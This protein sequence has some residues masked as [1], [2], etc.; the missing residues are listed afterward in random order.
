MT[1]SKRKKGKD[2]P[3]PK[4][5]G[6]PW[7]V[8]DMWDLA[9]LW[10]KPRTVES[11]ARELGRTGDAC[12]ARIYIIRLAFEL[13][14]DIKVKQADKLMESLSKLPGRSIPHRNE[15]AR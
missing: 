12:R 13:Y 4:N 11:I 5:H 2:N 1:T 8:E 3:F 10:E 7:T 6:M 14:K 9:T 15:S